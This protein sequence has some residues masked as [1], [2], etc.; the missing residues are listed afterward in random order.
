MYLSQI[1]CVNIYYGEI[2]LWN[3]CHTVYQV[4]VCVCVCVCVWQQGRYEAWTQ[5]FAFTKVVLYH[6]RHT[7]SPFCSGYFGD[8]VWRTICWGWPWTMIFPISASHVARTT[9]VSHW[10]LTQNQFLKYGQGIW[11][12]WRSLVYGNS[13]WQTF[14][15]NT[16]ITTW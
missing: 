15:Y 2:I 5:G 4:C 14:W 8:G 10:H 3:Q 9:Y 6:L 12:T 11:Y 13:F 7:S 16:F 1:T